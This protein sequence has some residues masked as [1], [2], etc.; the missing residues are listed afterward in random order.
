M[1]VTVIDCESIDDFHEKLKFYTK[2]I[3]V[4]YGKFLGAIVPE[5][6]ESWC[7]DCTTAKNKFEDSFKDCSLFSEFEQ[8]SN[9]VI[10]L[11]C[12]IDR[13]CFKGNCPYKNDPI[14]KLA[15]VPTLIKFKDAVEV[16][17]LN[18]RTSQDIEKIKGL[19]QL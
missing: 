12:N 5:T 8:K 17:R 18:D 14:I 19:L 2:D 3:S 10:I 9:N 15:C 6:G 7:C 11:E 4:I 13:T 16:H 1:N